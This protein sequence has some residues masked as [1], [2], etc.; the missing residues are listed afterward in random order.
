MSRILYAVVAASIAVLAAG[1]VSAQAL[2]EKAQ[3]GG[4]GGAKVFK[5]QLGIKP[6]Q[7]PGVCPNAAMMTAWVFT[8]YP[9]KV[10]IMIA[11]QS[12]GVAGPIS[13]S[14]VK[15]ANGQYLATYST[16]IPINQSVDTAYRVLVGG[17]QAVTSNWV[18]L[19]YECIIG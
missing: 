1:P 10:N 4:G 17:G 11:R 8:N 19:K 5:A 9:G 16:Q 3:G 14:L 7:A 6:P 13:V 15:A 18:P 2:D 12:G